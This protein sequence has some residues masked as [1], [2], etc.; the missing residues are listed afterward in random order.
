MELL[1]GT[2]N[3]QFHLASNILVR[4]VSYIMKQYKIP[5]YKTS[6]AQPVTQLSNIKSS[7][8]RLLNIQ[9]CKT[10]QRISLYTQNHTQVK[11]IFIV[12]GSGFLTIKTRIL[13]ILAGRQFHTSRQL[14]LSDQQ[15]S[16]PPNARL[17]HT[18]TYREESVSEIKIQNNVKSKKDTRCEKRCVCVSVLR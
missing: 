10:Q 7:K 6:S 5:F 8:V 11:Y 18:K 16:C 13:C 3:C 14:T 15:C 12:F 9:L 1:R 17:T 2:K 4:I